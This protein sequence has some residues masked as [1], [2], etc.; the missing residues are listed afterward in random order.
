M[1]AVAAIADGLMSRVDDVVARATNVR[2]A[3]EVSERRSDQ[4]HELRRLLQRLFRRFGA[5]ATDATPCG[6]P[7]SIAHAHALM[8]LLGR[9]ELSQQ[10]LGRELCIDKS[11]VARLCTK[12]ATAGHAMQRMAEGDGR[13]RRVSLT[14]R[15]TRLAR[16]TQVASTGRFGELLRALP[17]ETR[18]AV[19]ESLRH[20]LTAVESLTGPDPHQKGS[21]N[22]PRDLR[23]LSLRR[24]PRMSASG[25]PSI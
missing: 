15:G 1:S 13:S 20:L 24:V 19:L 3:V 14:A 21:T 6:Q 12:M 10:E 22:D 16:E 11:N 25:S 8:I 5:L 9:G 4:V 2:H 23:P 17:A 7:L 18:P